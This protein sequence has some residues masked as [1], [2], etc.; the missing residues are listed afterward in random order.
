MESDSKKPD[1]E[2]MEFLLGFIAGE[3]S[4]FITMPVDDRYKYGIS[5]VCPYTS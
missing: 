3:G 1:P 2:T 4:F 5:L